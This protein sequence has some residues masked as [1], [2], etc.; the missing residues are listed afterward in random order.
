V[1]RSR[2]GRKH[3]DEQELAVG[4]DQLLRE[5]ERVPGGLIV[6]DA[7]DHAFEHLTAPRSRE[8]RPRVAPGG[9]SGRHPVCVISNFVS[10]EKGAH[11]PAPRQHLS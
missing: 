1:L 7:Y 3:L 11:H 2:L 4:R 9:V 5:A 6:A 8:W 10:D